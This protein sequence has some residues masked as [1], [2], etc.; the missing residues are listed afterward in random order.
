MYRP[1]KSVD[2]CQCCMRGVA[3]T[4]FE[5][6]SNLFGDEDSPQIVNSSYDTCCLHI[7]FSFSARAQS[8]PCIKAAPAGA[9]RSATAQRAALGAEMRW[10]PAEQTEGLSLS[11]SCNP[12]V[13]SA[14]SPLYTRGPFP[15]P[16][17]I[18]QITMLLFV[19][20]ER[21]YLPTKLLNISLSSL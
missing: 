2:W 21:L 12:P 14:D 7:S 6:A 5:C 20:E 13:S 9:F 11:T 4:D 17:I 10:L 15:V 19:K 18:L 3:F 16:T 1:A 8:L